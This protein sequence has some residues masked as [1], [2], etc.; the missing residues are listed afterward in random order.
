MRYLKTY[1]A[2]Q[3]FYKQRNT[4][5]LIVDEDENW[6]LDSKPEGGCW[7]GCETGFNWRADEDTWVSLPIQE[8]IITLGPI[9]ELENWFSDA[10]HHEKS[11]AEKMLH[12]V[13]NMDIF[14][15]F[16][17]K[18]KEKFSRLI[19]KYPNG[20]PVVTV[21]SKHHFQRNNMKESVDNYPEVADDIKDWLMG[22]HPVLNMK[23][24]IVEFD[25]GF[26]KTNDDLGL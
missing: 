10:I 16:E 8:N 24:K 25:M 4:V 5:Y 11:E 6:V 15:T 21:S 23:F 1:E 14:T 22:G 12:I 7:D 20:L 19:E 2:L 26:Q 13:E 18:D 9:S 3:D 17:D